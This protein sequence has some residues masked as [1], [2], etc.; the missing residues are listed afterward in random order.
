M[1][2]E[3]GRSPERDPGFSR[4]K[5]MERARNGERPAEAEMDATERSADRRPNKHIDHPA[6]VDDEET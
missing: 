1:T 5:D 4:D 2:K 3:M 6:D